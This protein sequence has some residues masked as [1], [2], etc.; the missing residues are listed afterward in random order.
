MGILDRHNVKREPAMGAQALSS[1]ENVGQ[2]NAQATEAAGDWLGQSCE[3]VS[4]I[5]ES[6]EG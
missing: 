2:I 5:P 1:Y 6:R 3:Q 4:L